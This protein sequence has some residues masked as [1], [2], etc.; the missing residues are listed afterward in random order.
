AQFAVDRYLAPVYWSAVVMVA[1]F[2]TIVADAIHVGLRIPYLVSS[3]GFGVALVLIFIVWYRT[4]GTL[5]IHH[6]DT[7]RRELFYWATVMA[8]FALGTAAGDLAAT[9][10][11]LGFFGSG[12]MFTGFIVLP[13]LGYRFLGLDSIA[14]FWIAYVLTRPLGA[15][16]ADWLGRA[17]TLSGVGLGTGL[18]GLVLTVI[19][20]AL[21]GY[22]SVTRRD[23][24]TV[25]E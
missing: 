3:L 12:V 18:V 20:V 13:A 8:T 5:S 15:S 17:K 24:D 11:G 19:I 6:I 1:I 4:E 25:H 2:G 14:A 9:T 16:F 23:V 21:V 22:L 7:R 10:F